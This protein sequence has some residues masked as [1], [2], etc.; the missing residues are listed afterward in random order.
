MLEVQSLIKSPLL[1]PLALEKPAVKAF[2]SLISLPLPPSGCQDKYLCTSLCRGSG[3][4][5]SQP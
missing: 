4:L 5:I 3:F 1:P 2:E